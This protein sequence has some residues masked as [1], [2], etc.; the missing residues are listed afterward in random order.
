MDYLA[1][2]MNKSDKEPGKI[3]DEKIIIK[4]LAQ[5]LEIYEKYHE[6]ISFYCVIP[7]FNMVEILL[8]E[9]IQVHKMSDEKISQGQ[10]T[11]LKEVAKF[12]CKNKRVYISENLL[13]TFL[14]KRLGRESETFPK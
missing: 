6:A 8:K 13:E 10:I 4:K 14:V 5:M 9:L 2:D 1:K 12:C 7:D 11:F 3:K